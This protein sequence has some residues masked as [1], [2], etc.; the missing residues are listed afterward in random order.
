MTLRGPSIERLQEAQDWLVEACPVE[1]RYL[2]G[3]RDALG[4]VLGDYEP[5][6]GLPPPAPCTHGGRWSSVGYLWSAERAE[7]WKRCWDRPVPDT[8]VTRCEA[9]GAIV[10]I[11]FVALDRD[12][13]LTI[14]V[15]RTIRIPQPMCGDE[16]VVELVDDPELGLGAYVF[17]AGARQWRGY[18]LL[19]SMVR[20]GRA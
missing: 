12:E 9:C 17:A 15:G 14:T 4:W 6:E 10:V 7:R 18:E 5:P 11:R 2:A 8:R 3:V 1:D 16:P 19:A 13:E 20:G